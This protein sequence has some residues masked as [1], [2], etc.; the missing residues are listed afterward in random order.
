MYLLSPRKNIGIQILFIIA[1]TLLLV[2]CGKGTTINPTPTIGGTSPL[3]YSGVLAVDADGLHIQSL[4][5]IECP[6]GSE[7]WK[8]SPDRLVLANSR[9]SYDTGELQQI[10]KYL[11]A[12]YRTDK[13]TYSINKI[14]IPL[15]TSLRW[16]V[17][18]YNVGQNLELDNAAYH[19]VGEETGC[20]ADMEITNIGSTTIQIP[21][22]GLRLTQSPRQTTTSTV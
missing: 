18:G 3:N 4:T 6:P 19:I 7:L 21:Q 12:F 8:V 17:G 15:P 20:V 10:V 5:G 1:L 16:V 2:G 9:V 22:A 13:T 11:D 14:N